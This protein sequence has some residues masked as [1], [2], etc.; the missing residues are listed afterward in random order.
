M[1]KAQLILCA[2]LIAVT[3]S[4]AGAE[5]KTNNKGT[6]ACNSTGTGRKDGKDQDGNVMNC[7]W[8]TCTYCGTVKGVIDCS[9]QATDYSNPTDCHPVAGITKPGGGIPNHAPII[10]TPS[11]THERKAQ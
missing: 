9:V 4:P 7:L 2:L 8:E 6:T 5:P 1:T 3:T 10:T 11:S